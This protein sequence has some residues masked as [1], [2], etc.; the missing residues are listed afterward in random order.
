MG[1]VLISDTVINVRSLMEKDKIT[2]LLWVEE[3][4]N[5]IIHHSKKK[6]YQ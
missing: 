1:I 6:D 5:W 2:K 4:L 3:T